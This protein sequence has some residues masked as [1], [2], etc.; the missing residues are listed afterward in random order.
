MKII[1][2]LS[3]LISLNA[4]AAPGKGLNFDDFAYQKILLKASLTRGLYVVPSKRFSLK[5][6]SPTPKSQGKT[7]TC[8][9]WAVAYSA[10]T[11]SEAIRHGW[12]NKSFITKQAFSPGFLY[13]LIKTNYDYTCT[14]GTS[15]QN[16]LSKLKN[17]G[18][19]KYNDL[20]TLCPATIPNSSYQ[21]ATAYKIKDFVRLFNTNDP[22]QIKIDTVRK[23]ISEKK[24]VIIAMNTPDSFSKS[25]RKKVWQA[26]E[27]PNINHGGHAMTVISYD[28]SKYG[29]A[30]E[31]Q[32]SWGTRWGNGGYIWVKYPDFA[33]FTYYALE[34][35]DH[36]KKSNYWQ[37]DLSGRLKLVLSYGNQMQVT[38]QNNIYKVKRPY[39][40]GTRFRLYISNNQ[41]AYVYAFGSD[42]TGKVYPIFPHKQG[43]SAALNY[44]RNEVP[45]P[46]EDHYIAMDNNVGHDFIAVLYSK[47]ELD[48]NKIQ[49]Q[50]EQQSGNFA[51]KVQKVLAH[52]LVRAR[53]IK[54]SSNI[55]SFKANSRGRTVVPL[56]VEIEHIK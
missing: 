47:D 30:F 28:D 11:I 8:T 37:T 39:R 15:I 32:N 12:K 42:L 45:I 14:K 29:G 20:P 17:I 2:I 10:R 55:I 7:G 44:K 43:I 16:A 9:A 1:F 27:N 46:D 40:S 41:P 3:L 24:P 50:I 22:A 51:Q 52:K 35:I 19:P 34:L 33:K 36:P 6:Y 26:T 31:L 23:S 5:Q 4:L 54:Y 13:K 25:H 48:I 53:N 49:Q 18:V 56:I 38:R 21:E